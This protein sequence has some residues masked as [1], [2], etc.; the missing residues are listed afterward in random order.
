MVAGRV[1][2]RRVRQRADQRPVV[3]AL[4][5]ASAGARRSHARRARGDRLELAAD[6]VRGVGLQVE[7][8]VLR[9]AAGEE[10]VDDRPGLPAPAAPAGGRQ[11]AQ[12]RRRGSCPGRADPIAPAWMAVRRDAI[13]W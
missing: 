11:G 1:V 13:G 5:P 9:Q 10:D 8:V 2:V 6:L 3:A 12:A 4:R 7:A